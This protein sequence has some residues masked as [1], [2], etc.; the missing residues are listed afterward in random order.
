MTNFV[1]AA[2]YHFTPLPEF[3][4]YQTPLQ[5]L[6]DE[7]GV[8]GILL[9]AS[10]G[11]N[12]TIA[13]SR[14]GIDNALNAIRA[15]PGCSNL[16]HKESF[17][18]E[19][20]FRR[21]KVRLKKEIVTMGVPG[22][23]P[24]NLVGT[25]VEPEAWN[26]LISRDDV[27]VIDT[28]NDYEVQIG[29]FKNAVDPNTRSFREF[30]EWFK[31][32]QRTHNKPKVA[33]FCTGG[34]R[35]EKSTAFAKS[36]GVDEVYHLKGGILKYLETVPEQE[37]LWEGDCFVFDRRVAVGHGLQLGD[38]DLCYACRRPLTTEDKAHEH[39]EKGVS[40]HRCM[41]EFTDER[42]A[43]FRQRQ[44]QVALAQKRGEDHIAQDVEAARLAARQAADEA[45]KKAAEGRNSES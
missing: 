9:L 31:E 37:S 23:D 22:V 27:V 1:V 45:R 39:Y 32:F 30:P 3:E 42:R 41:D 18:V 33:M 19:K 10:E 43:Q 8:C 13:G 12:G 17:A 14:E 34:I 25:Y 16:E 5:T 29:T 6:L 35:C 11:V 15:L 26:D 21:M 38:Y 44:Y 2:L 24:N 28:R 20:P 36:I 7:N 40:C 4:S